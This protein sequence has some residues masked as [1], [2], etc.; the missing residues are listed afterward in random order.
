VSEAS[1]P[2]EPQDTGPG[3]DAGV[4]A[5]PGGSGDP[6][7][8]AGATRRHPVRG[9]V[10]TI[11]KLAFA[12]ALI[13]WIVHK[14]DLDPEAFRRPLSQPGSLA[15]VL[16]L[17]TI[18]LSLGGV[19]WALLLRNE[20]IPVPFLK[21]LQL[22]WIGHFWNMVIP[23]AVS[24]DAVKMFYVGQQAPGRREEAWTTVLADRMIGLMALVSVGALAALANLR[25]MWGRTELRAI[26]LLMVGILA[27]AILGGLVL[28]TDLGRRSRLVRELGPRIPFAANLVRAYDVL[29]RLMRK[30]KTVLAAFLLS[31][32][33]HSVAVTNA[34]LLGRAAGEVVLTATQ[35]YVLLPVAM[36]SNA[37]PLTPFGNIG[38]GESVLGKLFEW[39]GAPASS[40]VTVMLLLRAT[41]LAMALLGALLYA[42]YGHQA[43]PGQPADPSADPALGVDTGP[44]A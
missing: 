35:Y 16:T 11:L 43:V 20:G 1:S 36:V 9:A 8:G 4:D 25:F 29:T 28:A 30:P 2:T 26:F 6:G 38:V 13:G 18:G 5:S 37:V 24:G 44:G 3:P 23:G 33:S 27:V 41:L 34:Y 32:V 19:R 22:T 10:L 21:V 14:G 12:V 7:A 15:L 17:S 39:S 40:G 42:F 31:F